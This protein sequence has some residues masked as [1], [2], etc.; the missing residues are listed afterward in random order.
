MSVAGTVLLIRQ[1]GVIIRGHWVVL[2]LI[3]PKLDFGRGGCQACVEVSRLFLSQFS[4]DSRFHILDE[5]FAINAGQD[6]V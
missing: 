2:C 1:Q 4:N 6:I 3:G 5:P